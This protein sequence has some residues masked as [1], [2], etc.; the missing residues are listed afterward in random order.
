MVGPWNEQPYTFRALRKTFGMM[1]L[2]CDVCRSSAHVSAG[3]LDR[4]YRN[5]S[6]DYKKRPCQQKPR[7]GKFG[8]GKWMHAT[9]GKTLTHHTRLPAS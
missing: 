3:Y 6:C 1:W 9:T 5:V 2:C 8:E 4:Y 7:Q